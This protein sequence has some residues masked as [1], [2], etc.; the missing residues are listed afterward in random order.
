MPIVSLEHLLEASVPPLSVAPRRRSETLAGDE[1][2][3]VGA[4]DLEGAVLVPGVPVVMSEPAY[5]HTAGDRPTM[6]LAIAAGCHPIVCEKLDDGVGRARLFA[7]AWRRL[8]QAR[9]STEAYGG[10][11][12]LELP[13]RWLGLLTYARVAV[14]GPLRGI[15]PPRMPPAPS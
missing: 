1:A 3:D 14:R 4:I 11:T 10:A 8:E 5:D 7:A 13:H 9:A 12:V 2:D 15:T 6:E